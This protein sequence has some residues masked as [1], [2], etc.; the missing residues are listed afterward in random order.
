MQQLS[1][2]S[3]NQVLRYQL[4]SSA[5][6]AAGWTAD[7]ADSFK[8]IPQNETVFGEES[9]RQVEQVSNDF[10][11]LKWQCHEFLLLFSQ[12]VPLFGQL[13]SRQTGEGGRFFTTALL[14]HNS[15]VSLIQR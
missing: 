11:K 9:V 3:D 10:V 6:T 13:T 1:D 8:P 5:D 14:W 2:G 7:L 15:P 4:R 12:T